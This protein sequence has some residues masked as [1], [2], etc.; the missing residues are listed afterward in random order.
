MKTTCSIIAAGLLL[1]LGGCQSANTTSQVAPGAVSSGCC[2]GERF[3]SEGCC[4]ATVCEVNAAK[5][6]AKTQD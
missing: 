5:K 2:E 6:S 1:C 4:K 3:E